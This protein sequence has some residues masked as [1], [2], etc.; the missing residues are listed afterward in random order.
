LLLLINCFCA[1]IR[2]FKRSTF[3]GTGFLATCVSSFNTGLYIT[4]FL[5]AYLGLARF[6]I[7][8]LYLPALLFCLLPV[9]LLLSAALVVHHI[10]ITLTLTLLLTVL[11]LL[12]FCCYL[13]CIVVINRCVVTVV[14]Y[15]RGVIIIGYRMHVI[16]NSYIFTI[17]TL[18]VY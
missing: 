8:N 3:L 17:V 18:L 1:F 14:I 9:Q 4:S 12:P 5:L 7:I 11:L 15:N 16:Y 6:V 13:P 10:V 2:A